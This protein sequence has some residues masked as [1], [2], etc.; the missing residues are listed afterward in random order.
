[1][2]FLTLAFIGV[3]YVLIVE[4]TVSILGIGNTILYNDAFIEAIKVVEIPII[5]RT[6]IFYL[7][8]GLTSLFAGMIMVFLAILEFVCRIFPRVD[9][10]WMTLITCAALY[11]LC[12][13]ALGIRDVEHMID[14]VAPYLVL[15]SGVLIPAALLAAARVRGV[16][17]QSSGG[18]EA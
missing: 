13:A 7:T 16:R 18:N 12:L 14:G 11:A 10:R 4:S 2:A 3:F 5:E 1:M 9:R 15:T 8:V 6:D 17:G